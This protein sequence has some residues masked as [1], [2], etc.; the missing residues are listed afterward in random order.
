MARTAA[1]A[2]ARG[3]V[4]A[5]HAPAAVASR[6]GTG[7]IE[8][9]ATDLV[10]LVG[11]RLPG[12]FVLVDP[13]AAR[14]ERML[15]GPALTAALAGLAVADATDAALVEAVAA[16]ERLISAAT[17]A[18]ARVIEELLARR[19]RDAPIGCQAAL[20]HSR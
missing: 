1:T 9:T 12:R 2:R 3:R 6:A 16:H 19:G 14:L 4:M 18:Q 7:P 10:E 15:P 11:E 17:A 8:V 13:V 5:D 20:S